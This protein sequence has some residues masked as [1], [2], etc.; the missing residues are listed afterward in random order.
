Y[1]RLK[2]RI[3]TD[4]Y[5]R[6]H[7]NSEIGRKTDKNNSAHQRYLS[8]MLWQAE[9]GLVQFAGGAMN[10]LGN[11]TI[12]K[13]A[14][15]LI[16]DGADKDRLSLQEK[17]R[18]RSEELEKRGITARMDDFIWR[19]R[20]IDA[21]G[22]LGVVGHARNLEVL[23]LTGDDIQKDLKLLPELMDQLEIVVQAGKTRR[24]SEN[25]YYMEQSDRQIELADAAIGSEEIIRRLQEDLLIIGHITREGGVDTDQSHEEVKRRLETYEEDL[26]AYRERMKALSDLSKPKYIAGKEE[27]PDKAEYNEVKTDEEIE[28]EAEALVADLTIKN[29]SDRAIYEKREQICALQ[30]RCKDNELGQV[31][32]VLAARAGVVWER[33]RLLNVEQ[34]LKSDRRNEQL[35][36]EADEL[37]RRE[38]LRHE[39]KDANGKTIMGQDETL[40]P[41]L[42]LRNI[43]EERAFD[44][45][46]L[47]AQ[48]EHYS[49]QHMWA[50]NAEGS[51]MT[52]P[53]ILRKI[54]RFTHWLKGGNRTMDHGEVKYDEAVER[55]Q[56]L[57]EE[58]K[59]YVPGVPII[60]PSGVDEVPPVEV[61]RYYDDATKNVFKE[62]YD[63]LNTLLEG[64]EENA[65][66]PQLRSALEAMGNYIKVRIAVTTDTTEMEMAFLDK[67]RKDANR[68]FDSKNTEMR[69][70]DPVVVGL[71]NML[72]KVDSMGRGDLRQEM[73]QAEYKVAME[74]P[75][76][77]VKYSEDDTMESNVKDIPL[78]LHEP[79]LNDVKQGWAGDCYF[80]S[81]IAAVIQTDPELIKKMFYDAG[82]GTVLVRLYVGLDK[83]NRRMDNE[84]KLANDD[85][86]MKPVYIRVR[87]D[88]DPGGGMG[89]DCIWVQLLEK[90]VAA[91]GLVHG[92]SKVKEDGRLEKMQSEITNGDP[93]K[94]IIHITGHRDISSR[95]KADYKE[96]EKH[97]K[98]EDDEIDDLRPRLMLKGVPLW[99]QSFVWTRIEKETKQRERNNGAEGPEQDGQQDNVQE[100]EEVY[101]NKIT[102]CVKEVVKETMD[103]YREA[104][105]KLLES[106]K[107]KY[108]AS[109]AD[110]NT[111]REKMEKQ[112]SVDPDEMAEKVRRNL[113]GDDL[114]V[115]DDGK[116]YKD[117]FAVI[118]HIEEF[119]EAEAD[120]A[121]II[122]YVE[123]KAVIYEPF[124][125]EPQTSVERFEKVL[126]FWEREA[127]FRNKIIMETNPKG[128]Y[129]RPEMC[130]LHDI[131]STIKDGGTVS[132][133][134]SGHAM[135]II[136]V[137]LKNGRWFG[138][139]RDTN[140]IRRC[141]YEK[142]DEGQL[143]G[144]IESSVSTKETVRKLDGTLKTAVYGTTW[145]ELKDLYK[146]MLEY[147]CM[148]GHKFA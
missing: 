98:P 63:N 138:M 31:L 82:D 101:R 84:D 37:K 5:Y 121:A 79:N 9:G 30:K 13:Y 93:R 77:Y 87:K 12:K 2:K 10:Y 65:Y 107:S 80:H 43:A 124:K 103:T 97:E 115:L 34:A 17:L 57:P 125:R 62:M 67:F 104:F 110:I 106:L 122:K 92:R 105:D 52:S 142:D 128:I 148:P 133:G 109:E 29:L 72:D 76:V 95:D 134:V 145:W 39:H 1:Y 35:R 81:A 118:G 32:E 19:T 102:A 59:N 139:V 16:R 7:E 117:P 22:K 48:A 146:N 136:D 40:E 144:K 100:D 4:G 60:I 116:D 53:W 56:R 140:S 71:L 64:K 99:L 137:K 83:N 69:L 108:N 119:F 66:P 143:K 55:L 141:E 132:Y 61:T 26:K 114:V 25:T 11:N 6:G 129:T 28:R 96:L 68:C 85:V 36:A 38:S 75:A 131:R 58:V 45:D 89:E 86:R 51:P 147:W 88:Y 130:F 23:D 15:A 126:K 112:Y 27:S 94:M 46:D 42:K 135:N 24:E 90:A 123:E 74:Q 54:I 33:K 20:H 41:I 91:A 50:V 47:R 8:E 18:K 78:F 113:N 14:K 44:A 3:M 127:R 21:R 120:I 70:D 49:N 111:L 73:T